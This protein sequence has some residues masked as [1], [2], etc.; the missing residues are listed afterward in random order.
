MIQPVQSSISAP[1]MPF[2]PTNVNPLYQDRFGISTLTSAD[3]IRKPLI[4]VGILAVVAVL[5]I[6]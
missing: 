5:I 4:F 2:Q 6:F 3:G 1:S